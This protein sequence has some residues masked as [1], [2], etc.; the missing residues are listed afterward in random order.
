[1]SIARLT[2]IGTENELN[3][4]NKSIADTWSLSSPNFDKDTLLDTIILKGGQFE[5]LMADPLYFHRFSASWWKKWKDTFEGWF[6]V[7]DKEYE[8]LWNT[9]RYEEYHDDIK[10]VGTNDTSTSN[11][12]V[13]DDDATAASTVNSTDTLDANNTGSTTDAVSAYDS[14]NYSPS[15]KSDTT[16]TTHSVDV[17]TTTTNSTST[18]DRTTVNTGTVDND[19]TNDRDVDHKLHAWGNIGVMSS[20]DLYMQE[21]KVR[22]WNFY[23]H[24]A[25]IFVREMC[26]RVY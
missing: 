11:R 21:V 3:Y 26:V 24:M 7:K 14:A 8:P 22:Y 10:D 17:N 16:G 23:E 12:E 20:Q 18:D 15:S 2:L 9:D 25:D 6:I 4:L 19:T 13:V 5:T 1:M